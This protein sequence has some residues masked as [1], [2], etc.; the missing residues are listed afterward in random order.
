MTE[1][2]W[3]DLVHFTDIDQFAIRLEQLEYWPVCSVCGGLVKEELALAVR[4]HVVTNKECL[5]LVAIMCGVK[6]KQIAPMLSMTERGVN[7]AYR[8]AVRAI[9]EWKDCGVVTVLLENFGRAA[10]EVLE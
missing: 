4:K 8:R 1:H 7:I 2:P 6:A 3:R 10:L 5:V 9:N